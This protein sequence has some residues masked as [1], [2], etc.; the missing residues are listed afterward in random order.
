MPH[1]PKVTVRFKRGTRGESEIQAW[2]SFCRQMEV[3]LPQRYQTVKEFPGRRYWGI[4]NGSVARM[5]GWFD[6]GF[7]GQGAQGYNALTRWLCSYIVSAGA[8][9]PT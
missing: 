3:K 2:K 4:G 8:A 5:H 9:K 1:E 7:V 6:A